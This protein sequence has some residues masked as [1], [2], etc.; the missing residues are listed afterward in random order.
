MREASRQ[1]AMQSPKSAMSPD[2]DRARRRRLANDWT[3]CTRLITRRAS[4]F[5]YLVRGNVALQ[6]RLIAIAAYLG[7][8]IEVLHAKPFQDFTVDRS[9]AAVSRLNPNRT[10]DR[11]S[12]DRTKRG[13]G[14]ESAARAHPQFA[15]KCLIEIAKP[16][17]RSRHQALAA[18]ADL[19]QR[20]RC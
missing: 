13:G 9:Q 5:P 20:A 11:R 19:P 10:R 7:N 12:G 8:T 15:F 18:C 2:T 6:I 14:R 1:I 16:A 17:F 4:A 3:H